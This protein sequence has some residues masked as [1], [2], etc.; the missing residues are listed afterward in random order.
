MLTPGTPGTGH[1][2]PLRIAIGVATLVVLLGLVA[3]ASRTGVGRSSRVEPTSSYGSWALSIFMVAFVLT[4][5]VTLYAYWRKI[6][7]SHEGPKARSFEAR[8][9]GTLAIVLCFVLFAGAV[10]FYREHHRLFGSGLHIPGLGNTPLLG[11]KHGSARSD[12]KFEWPVL[13]AALLLLTVGAGWAWWAM[14]I[15]TTSSTLRVPDVAEDITASIAVAIDDLEAEPDARRAVIAAYARMEGVFA[16]HGLHRAPS[17]TAVEYL[18]RLL[19]DV[20]SRAD[21]VARLTGLFERA[22]FSRHEI[23]GAMKQDAIDALR[24]IRDDLQPA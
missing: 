19:L 21:A 4:I 8:V 5:P 6:R 15:R 16:R 2:R 22:K 3:F 13:W 24:A 1:G 14:R 20:T 17:E 12:P 10:V 23:D 9:M 18:R 7:E 11:G